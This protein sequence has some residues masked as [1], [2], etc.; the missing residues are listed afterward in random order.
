MD[1]GLQVELA[2]VVKVEVLALGLTLRAHHGRYGGPVSAM[3]SQ[4]LLGDFHLFFGP[5]GRLYNFCNSTEQEISFQLNT[6][7]LLIDCDN[8]FTQ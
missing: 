8:I 2:L 6:V 3:L 4:T 1:Q 5:S 7:Y